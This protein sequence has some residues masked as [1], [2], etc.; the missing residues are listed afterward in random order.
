MR[1]P[2]GGVSPEVSAPL[3]GLLLWVRVPLGDVILEVSAPIGGF[4]LRGARS[5]EG[6]DP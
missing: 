4:A 6:C 1:V 2:L 3:G 5:L